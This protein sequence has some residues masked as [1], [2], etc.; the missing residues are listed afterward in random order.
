[1]VFTRTPSFRCVHWA[2]HTGISSNTFA[3]PQAV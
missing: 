3:V 2:M 1:M